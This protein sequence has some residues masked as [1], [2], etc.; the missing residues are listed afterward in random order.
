MLPD[1]FSAHLQQTSGIMTILMSDLISIVSILSSKV[2]VPDVGA[3]SLKN[4]PIRPVVWCDDSSIAIRTV[5]I[6]I[7]RDASSLRKKDDFSHI[8]MAELESVRKSINLVLKWGLQNLEVKTNFAFVC[9]WIETI[10][11]E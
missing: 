8:N 6:K 11:K 10:I 7:V 4:R 5:D 9:E 2:S 1:S 3:V